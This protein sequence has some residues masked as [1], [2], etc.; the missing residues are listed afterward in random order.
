MVPKSIALLIA[1]S[2]TACAATAQDT[3]DPEGSRHRDPIVNGTETKDYPAAGMLLMQGQAW[4]TGTLISPNK[5][6]TAAHCLEGADPASLSFG[7]GADQY[8]VDEEVPVVDAV[9]HPQWESQALTN[10]IGVM[11][12]AYDA[13][14]A[15]ITM[16]PKMDQTWIGR[17]VLLVGYGVD[18]G[19]SQ[20]NGGIKRMVDVTIDQIDDT[21]LHYTTEQ[22]KSACN[23]DSGGPAFY[24]ENGELLVVGVTSWGDQAC[25]EFGVY[26]RVDAYLDWIDQEVAK[27]PDPNDPTVDPNDPNNPYPPSGPTDPNDPCQGETWE[28]RCEGN[29]VVWCEY[30]QVMAIDCPTGCGFNQQAGY[31]DCL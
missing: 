4:C 10:D 26:T 20:S 21:T 17:V 24:E 16:N 23:G 12:L 22:G 6:L 3:D 15:P 9:M 25:Q 30:G 19:P 13:T 29:T 7:I 11:T 1:V 27:A 2:T 8:Q 31:F 5:V 18:D 28:G 14:V